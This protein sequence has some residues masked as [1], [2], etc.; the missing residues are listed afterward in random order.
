MTQLTDRLFTGIIA[1][2]VWFA[3]VLSLSVTIPGLAYSQ[4]AQDTIIT[5]DTTE[6]TLGLPQEYVMAALRPKYDLVNVGGTGYLWIVQTKPGPF[7]P[8]MLGS[9][10]FQDGKLV[11]I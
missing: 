3:V 5:F 10:R 11:V 7:P 6:L 9:L 8:K 2:I 1:N 4:T